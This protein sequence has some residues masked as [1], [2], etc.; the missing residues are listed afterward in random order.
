ME[1]APNNGRWREANCEIGSSACSSMK[2]C[3]PLKITAG[4]LLAS[5]TLRADRHCHGLRMCEK[6]RFALR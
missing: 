4:R 3:R 5:F 1:Y 6:G 2:M